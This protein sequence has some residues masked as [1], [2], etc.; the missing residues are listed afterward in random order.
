MWT[1]TLAKEKKAK[2]KDMVRA[3]NNGMLVLTD[4]YPL[5]IMPECSEGLLLHR[6][7][8]SKGLFRKIGIWEEPFNKMAKLSRLIMPSNY[9]VRQK[10]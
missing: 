8:K 6:Y 7:M 1:V 10:S 4:C 2:M 5:V 9:W 3:R